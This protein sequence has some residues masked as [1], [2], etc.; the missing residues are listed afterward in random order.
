M[1][2]LW[3][4]GFDVPLARLRRSLLRTRPTP[5]QWTILPTP[6]QAG[7]FTP[8]RSVFSDRTIRAQD[9][10]TGAAAVICST[11]EL[12]GQTQSKELIQLIG[13]A[14]ES[15]FGDPRPQLIPLKN[16][17]SGVAA[18][19]GKI[20]PEILASN[21]VAL[22]SNLELQEA[23]RHFR[24]VFSFLEGALARTVEAPLVLDPLELLMISVPLYHVVLALLHSRQTATIEWISDQ[25]DAATSNWGPHG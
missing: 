9:V 15:T 6:H 21:V 1:Q 14:L 2:F 10:L 8:R 20:L 22:A 5:T 24:K 19:L 3:L 13:I 4:A 16:D 25:I 18:I 12:R 11:F 7:G 23:R 17:Y